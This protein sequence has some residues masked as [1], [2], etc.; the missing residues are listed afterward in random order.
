MAYV[1]GSQ[2]GFIVLPDMLQYAPFFNRIKLWRKYKGHA[3]MGAGGGGAPARGTSATIL[4]KS[5]QRRAHVVDRQGG[6]GGGGGVGGG[7]V[8]GIGGARPYGNFAGG[9]GAGAAYSQPGPYAQVPPPLY[10]MHVSFA[11]YPPMP[12]A[13]SQQHQQQQQPPPMQ[14]QRP[15]GY[16]PPGT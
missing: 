7:G 4:Q 13:P 11:G 12:S 3:V 5:S 2:V 6:G 10:P 14:Q 9:A 15:A 1:R 8:P 16:R